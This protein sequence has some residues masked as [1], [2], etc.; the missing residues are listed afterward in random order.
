MIKTLIL[1]VSLI[2]NNCNLKGV[3][4]YIAIE[5]NNSYLGDVLRYIIIPNPNKNGV[6]IVKLKI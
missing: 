4:G 6:E 3:F 2:Q 1:S 5:F